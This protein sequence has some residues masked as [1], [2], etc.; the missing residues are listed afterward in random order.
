M[1]GECKRYSAY[2]IFLQE[3]YLTQDTNIKLYSQKY[4]VWYYSDSP[5]KRAKG[6]AIGLAKD[7]RFQLEERLVDRDGRFIFLKGILQ[8][9][10]CTLANIYCPNKNPTRYLIEILGKLMEFKK[11][12]IILAG[13]FNI[14]MDPQVDSTSS[15]LGIG[16]NKGS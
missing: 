6:F 7:V 15:A 12:K 2:I 11:G 8:G 14:G 10:E 4:P 3:T 1:L 16:S 13:D 5:I 9:M